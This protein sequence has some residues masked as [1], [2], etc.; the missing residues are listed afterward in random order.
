MAM[1]VL[2]VEVLHPVLLSDA[3]DAGKSEST[4]DRHVIALVPVGD[5]LEPGHEALVGLGELALVVEVGE[6]ALAPVLLAAL[7]AQTAL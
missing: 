2:V 7:G 1:P 5:V 6:I 3:T 4:Q